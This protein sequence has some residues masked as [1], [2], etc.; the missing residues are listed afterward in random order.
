MTSYGVNLLLLFF[1]SNS[2]LIHSRVATTITDDAV[3]WLQR[4]SRDID[5]DRGKRFGHAAAEARAGVVRTRRAR[6]RWSHQFYF[7]RT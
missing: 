5:R 1:F 7:Y 6:G 3:N 2:Y 4:L